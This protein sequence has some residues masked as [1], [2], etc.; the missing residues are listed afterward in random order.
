LGTNVFQNNPTAQQIKVPADSVENYKAA[1]NWST[2]AD[3]I[4]A[5]E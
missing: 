2:Y 5:I 3:K 1:T 4:S